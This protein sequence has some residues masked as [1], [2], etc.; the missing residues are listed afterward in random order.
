MG[1]LPSVVFLDPFLIGAAC[2]ILRP[3]LVIQIPLY[4]FTNACLK[5]LGWLPPEFSVDLRSID[6]ITAIMSWSICHIGDLLPI[7]LAICSGRQFVKDGT[8]GIDDFDVGL[9]VPTT[10]I[11]S[12]PHPSP[13]QNAPDGGAV[14]LNIEPVSDLPP[15]AVNRKRLPSES[16]MNDE[17]DKLFWKVVRTVVVRTIGSQHRE[18]VSVMIGPDKMI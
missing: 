16:I 14:V 12:L 8:E 10:D 17:R 11:I 9:L 3:F 6:G 5:G 13:F 18:S 2:Y 7:A 4:R 1:F 15:I